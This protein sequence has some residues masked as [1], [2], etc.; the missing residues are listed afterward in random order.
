MKVIQE[1]YVDLASSPSHTHILLLCTTVFQ[2]GEIIWLYSFPGGNMCGLILEWL[3]APQPNQ[4]QEPSYCGHNLSI[5]PL[6]WEWFLDFPISQSTYSFKCFSNENVKSENVPVDLNSCWLNFVFANWEVWIKFLR[7]CPAPVYTNPYFTFRY[8]SFP[9][10]FMPQEIKT[11]T[12]DPSGQDNWDQKVNWLKVVL[13]HVYDAAC[14]VLAQPLEF[15]TICWNKPLQVP[16]ELAHI[17]SG[18]PSPTSFSS[19]TKS[20]AWSMFGMEITNRGYLQ[21]DSSIVKRYLAGSTAGCV[22]NL[23]GTWCH[24][25]SLLINVVVALV[26]IQPK[27][28]SPLEFQ[29]PNLDV[30]V[31]ALNHPMR[32]TDFQQRVGVPASAQERT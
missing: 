32:I 26:I 29:S 9:V 24:V 5:Y 20:T 7:C 28:E 25:K 23:K 4:S 8:F 2:A 19:E 18:S 27:T 10:D 30:D 11:A 17:F 6:S 22:K 16:A 31:A 14:R 3:L 15:A 1:I 12:A 21:Q 13:E